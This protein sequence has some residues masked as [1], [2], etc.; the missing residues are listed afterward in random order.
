MMANVTRYISCFDKHTERLVKEIPL[1][2]I[3]LDVL[4]TLFRDSLDDDNDPMMDMFRIGRSQAA[5]LT[6]YAQGEID[7]EQFDCFLDCDAATEPR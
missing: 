7:V 5:A 6:P 1:P 2:A 4:H 3:S